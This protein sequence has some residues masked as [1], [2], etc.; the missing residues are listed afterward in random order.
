V[1]VL[2]I[3]QRVDLDDSILG[4]VHQ[5]VE[6]LAARV[7]HLHVLALWLG[8]H[9]LPP[10]VSLYSMGKDRGFG[11]LVQWIN[12][13]RVVGK[14][15]GQQQ[16]DVVFIHMLERYG[17]LAAPYTLL[18]RRPM[19]LFKAHHGIPLTL[20]LA[21]PLF[22]KMATSTEEGL[23]LRTVKKVVIGQGVDTELF[24]PADPPP[25]RSGSLLVLSVGRISPVKDYETLIQ[26]ADRLV[27]GGRSVEVTFEVIGDAGTEAQRPYQARLQQLVQELK[28]EKYFHF[29][30]AVPNREII[31]HLQRCDLFVNLSHTDS[32]DKAL[33]EAM[34]CARP[35]LTSNVAFRNVLGEYRETLM[36]EKGDPQALAER[37]AWI[38]GWS[39][40]ERR[41]LG[42]ALRRIVVEQHNIERFM[43]KLVGIFRQVVE[44]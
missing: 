6:K 10:N 5:W 25:V 33:L 42:T 44:E 14:L 9:R 7:D 22:R 27:N 19:V 35:I 28:L 34:A 29:R 13:N 24:R 38:Q 37:I 26:A 3:T 15:V 30:P 12:F 40:A 36:V 1:K 39:D 17:L 11:K 41:E 4:F 20:R 31:Q 2:M 8:R 43:D 23:E 32:L 21:H 16:V 18:T